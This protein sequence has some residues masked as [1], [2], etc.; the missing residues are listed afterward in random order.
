MA[1]ALAF[2]GGALA[3]LRRRLDDRAAAAWLDERLMTRE[4][5]S[6]ALGLSRPGRRPGRFDE[7]VA[8]RAEAAAAA[9][10]ARHPGWPF[11][12][13]LRRAL[14][15]AA[16]C[17]ALPAI[18]VWA[19]PSALGNAFRA[20]GSE[21][22]GDR[23]E[24]AAGQRSAARQDGALALASGADAAAV[25]RGRMLGY[26]PRTENRAVAAEMDRG[27]SV[28]GRIAKLREHR[29]PWQRVLIEVFV[30]L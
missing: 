27:S 6:A 12:A 21:G 19:D 28:S 16:A 10:A 14:P 2:C 5:L 30:T 20:G 22:G 23:L 1:S 3:A 17:L 24:V 25:A 8:E 18:L 9:P 7:E 13:L 11:A 26:L 29:N 15:A 4:L